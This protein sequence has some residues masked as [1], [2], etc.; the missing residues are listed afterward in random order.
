MIH[1]DI[2]FHDL[3]PGHPSQDLRKKFD[4]IAPY[5]MDDESFFKMYLGSSSLSTLFSSA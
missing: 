5:D 4:Q 3:T 1:L 2:L